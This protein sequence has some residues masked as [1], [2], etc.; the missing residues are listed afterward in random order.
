MLIR[1]AF[2]FSESVVE[3]DSSVVVVAVLSLLSTV[4][5][6]SNGYRHVIFMHGLLAGR[7][8]I[9]YFEKFVTE[10]SCLSFKNNKI[11]I[12]FILKK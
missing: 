11:Q 3:M 9:K 5:Q 4:V 2:D 7:E 6:L 12:K 1:A 8:E 10:V